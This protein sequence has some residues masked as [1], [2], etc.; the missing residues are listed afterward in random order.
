[1][2]TKRS[3]GKELVIISESSPLV[4][5][6]EGKADDY[7]G[8]RARGKRREE[9]HEF[10]EGRPAGS[11]LFGGDAFVGFPLGER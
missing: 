9:L 2:T 10:L 6:D 11:V 3:G 5:L 8:V 4:L 1:M 7:I